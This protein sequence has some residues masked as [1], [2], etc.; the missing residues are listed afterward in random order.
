MKLRIF[1]YL[2]L[3]EKKRSS[4]SFIEEK[5]MVTQIGAKGRKEESA[6]KKRNW[7]L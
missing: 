7:I 6:E 1:P 4:G 2:Y 3:A 5:T